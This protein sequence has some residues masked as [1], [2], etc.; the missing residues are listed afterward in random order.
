MA[1]H[2]GKAHSNLT[3]KGKDCPYCPRRY[4]LTRDM[5]LHLK[6]ITADSNKTEWKTATCNEIPEQDDPKERWN[7]L[8]E[9]NK[10]NI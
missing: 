8:N 4:A 9:K 6:I 5:L 2:I 10:P 3:R 7:K 1:T